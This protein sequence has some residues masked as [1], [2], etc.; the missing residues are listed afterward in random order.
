ML[1]D[2]MGNKRHL[3]CHITPYQMRL[4]TKLAGSMYWLGTKAPSKIQ[5]WGVVQR[6]KHELIIIHIFCIKLANILIYVKWM[7]NRIDMLLCRL[8][9]D[10]RLEGLYTPREPFED[11]EPLESKMK[12]A[13]RKGSNAILLTLL[14]EPMCLLF[15]H[16]SI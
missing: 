12:W 10:N 13:P 15:K 2:R 16:F 7:A 9:R 4:E 8:I 11:I 6:N 1:M 14:L 5:I 3:R